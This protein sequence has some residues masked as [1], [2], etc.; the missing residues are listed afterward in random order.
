MVIKVMSNIDSFR[1]SGSD[2]IPV[3]TLRNSE[4]ELSYILSHLVNIC[5]KEFVFQIA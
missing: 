5:L 1:A 2:F 4:S 3:V